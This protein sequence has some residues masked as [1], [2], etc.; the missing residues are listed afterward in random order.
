MSHQHGARRL[1]A[2]E[3]LWPRRLAPLRNLGVQTVWPLA[4]L[5]AAVWDGTG[6]FLWGLP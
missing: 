6:C 4:C 5:L 2:S 3:Q 1:P